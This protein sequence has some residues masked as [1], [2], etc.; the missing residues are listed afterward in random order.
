MAKDV[1]D[2]IMLNEVG[3]YYIIMNYVLLTLVVIAVFCFF[4]YFS[5]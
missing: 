1:S 4:R 3:I 2:V 5:T